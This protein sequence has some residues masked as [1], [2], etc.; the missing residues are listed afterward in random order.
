MLEKMVPIDSGVV[1]DQFEGH[2]D[3]DSS[4]ELISEDG[5]EGEVGQAAV[6]G[7]SILTHVTDVDID[8]LCV[9]ESSVVSEPESQDE[10]QEMGQFAIGPAAVAAVGTSNESEGDSD[11]IGFSLDSWLEMWREGKVLERYVVILC[12]RQRN[13]GQC[14]IANRQGTLLIQVCDQKCFGF[15]CFSRPRGEKL[16]QTIHGTPDQTLDP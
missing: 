15:V 16:N 1:S 2:W 13:S 9:G 6:E 5:M 11:F 8:N 10:M 7:L 4:L 3:A 12:I 14:Q